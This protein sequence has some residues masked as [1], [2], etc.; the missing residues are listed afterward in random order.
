MSQG[1]NA[2]SIYIEIELETKQALLALDRVRLELDGLPRSTDRANQALNR[3]ER[4]ADALGTGLSK[5]ASAIKVLI[6]VSALKEM[7]GMVQKHQEFA[8][9]VQMATSSQAEFNEVQARLLKTANGTFRALSEAQE[10]YITTADSLRSMGYSTSQAIDVQDSM[11]YAFVKN[12]T[13]AD[14]ASTAISAFSKA[15]NTGK[16]GAD[17]WETITSAIPSVINDIATASGKTSAQVRALG[18]AGKL[19]AKELTE[20][21]KQSL[22]ANEA[23][24]KGMSNTLVDATVRMNT[25]ITSLLVGFENNTGVLK[26]FTESLISAADS[27]LSFSEDTDGMKAATD[28]GVVAL[29]IFAS[30]MAGKLTSSL[31]GATTAQATNIKSTIQGIVATRTRAKEELAAASVTARKAALD[32]SAALSALNVATAEYQVARGSAAEALAMDNVN[33]TRSIYIATAAQASLANNAL[34]ASQAK[35]AATGL[36]M[37]NTMTALKT[38]TAP[39]GGPIGVIAAVAAGWYLYAQSQAEAKKESIAFADTLPDVIEKLK[40]L[41][42]EQLKGTRADTL[43]SIKNQK[44][45]VTGLSKEIVKLTNDKAAADRTM[46]DGWSWDRAGATEKSAELEI[47]LAQ[48]VRDRDSAERKLGDTQQAL[49]QINIQLNQSILDQMKAARDNALATA[50]AEKKAT[51]LGGAHALLAQ[52]LGTSTQALQAFNSESLKIDWGGAEGEKLIKQAKRRLEL[53]K[54]VGEARVKKQAEFD[55]EDAGVKNPQ[56]VTELQNIAAETYRVG[57]ARKKT[58]TEGK[59]SAATAETIAEKIANLKQQSEQAANSTNEM[60]RAQTILTAQQSLGKA[61]TEAQRV[62]VGKYAAAKWDATN[63]IRALSVAESLL[64][65]RQENTRYQQQT[66]DLK[67]ALESEGITRAEY[68]TAAEKAEQDHQNNLAKIRSAAVVNPIADNRGQIDPIQQLAN[69]NAKKLQLMRDY[70]AQEQAVLLQ[71]YQSGQMTHDQFTAAKTAT[72][73]QY[74]ALRTAQEKQFQEQQT[75]AQWQLLSQQGLGYDMLTSSIDAFAGNASNAITGLMTGTMSAQDAMRSLGNTI[76]NSA[77]N[78]VV[79]LGVEMLKNFILS[80]TLG[81]AGLAANA[82]A[83]IAGGSAALAAW[84][85]AA[86]AASIATAGAASGTGLTAYTAAQASG[87]ALTIMG[88]RKNGGPVSADGIYPVGEGNLPEFLQTRQGL[89]MIP[90][91]NGQVFSNKDVTGKPTIPKAPTGLERLKQSSTG[92]DSGSS[93][94]QPA[95]NVVINV[96][97]NTPTQVQHTQSYDQK[98]N[99][100]TVQEFITDMREKGPMHRSITENTTA[101]TKL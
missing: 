37:A 75:A 27:M 84:T 96:T 7:A 19:T 97:N 91:D 52:R 82:A 13:S 33:R 24:A 71:G 49:R 15:I 5:L 67:N 29:G 56:R 72:D 65:E 42:L 76:L 94:S 66:T 1:E 46:K 48:K 6:T 16:V 39:L 4:S 22:E 12:A 80:E 68:N 54:L 17:Q 74:L 61:A 28:A 88:G 59:K 3:T 92:K 9:R 40:E 32:K 31:V 101:S 8:E 38:I 47:Q 35:V 100:L 10:L 41:N 18:S 60:S 89:F 36:T 62:E 85:P 78:S 95:L 51:F 77:V 87:K 79:Q 70:Q 44:E 34:S 81:K 23:A 73:A 25:A 64:P 2:G 14:K 20:G 58:N 53:E 11:S 45:A 93:N 86:I 99:T 83:A 69:E 98:T 63:A 57:E 21:L 43:A 50:E 90:G 26:T 30:L 55:A